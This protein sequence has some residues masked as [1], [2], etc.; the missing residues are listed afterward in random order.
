MSKPVYG[1]NAVQSRNVEKISSPIWALVVAFIVFLVWTPFQVGVFNGQQ[2]DFEKPVYV[3]A[4][5]S[6][7]MLL[8]W[9]GLYFNKFKLE[10]QRDLLA[11][12]S[13][14]LPI[15]YAL[16]L[17]GA[18]S[19]YMAMN[20]LLIQSMYIAIFIIALYLLKQKQVNLVIQNAVLAVAYFIVGFDC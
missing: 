6:G 7:L 15:T 2:I 10:E 18:A 17:F 16:S 3:S 5:L 1:K 14:L 8:V 20:L 4:L 12:A 11:V 13:L 19:H 9:M